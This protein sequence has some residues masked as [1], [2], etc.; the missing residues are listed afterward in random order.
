MPKDIY[1]EEMEKFTCFSALDITFP[2]SSVKHEKKNVC[3]A[4]CTVNRQ[5]KY[6][7]RRGVEKINNCQNCVSLL[8]RTECSSPNSQGIIEKL[9][10]G[11]QTQYSDDGNSIFLKHSAMYNVTSGIWCRDLS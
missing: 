1:S 8:L 10:F 6:A 5:L 4:N 9:M 11:L 3:G 7:I 2:A